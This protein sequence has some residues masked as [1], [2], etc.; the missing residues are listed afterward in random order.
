MNK[1]ILV[2][3]A[4]KAGSTVEIATAIGETLAGRARQAYTAP[5]RLLLPSA[6]VVFFAG[7]MDYNK[8][9]FIDRTIAKAVEKNT[10][11]PSGDFRN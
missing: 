9:S 11:D 10:G 3:Y 7:K 2:T 8:L 6:Q 5:L 4:T 1:R